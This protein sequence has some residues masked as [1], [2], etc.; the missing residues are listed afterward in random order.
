[1]ELKIWNSLNRDYSFVKS[2][3][4]RQ[5]TIYNCGPTVYSSPH[6]GNIRRFLVADLL[7]RT[8]KYLKCDVKSI[9]NITDVGHLLDTNHEAA[10]T[11]RM[12]LAAEREKISPEE[13]AAKYTAEFFEALEKLNAEPAQYYPRATMHIPFMIEVITK[14][15]KRGYAYETASG[16]YYDVEKFKQ[17][18]KLSGNT[19]AEVEAGAR[20]AVREEKKHPQDFALWIKAPEEHVMQWDSPW[21]R[22]YPG[23]HIE[24]SAM[25]MH[26][27][28]ETIDIHTGGEDNKFPHHEN[29]IAQSEGATGKEFS[30]IWLHNAHL[31]VDN[32]KMSKSEGTFIKLEELE[33]R[34]FDPLAFR[35]LCLQT[36]YRSK[37]NFTWK[38]LEAASE[39]LSNLRQF[40]RNL[41]EIKTEA[42]KP[43][44]IDFQNSENKFS[45]A[46]ADDLGSP[47]AIAVVYDMMRA[48]NSYISKG[49]IGKTEAKKIIQVLNRFNEVL[50][51]IDIKKIDASAIVPHEVSELLEKRETAR[52][53]K[54]FKMADELRKLIADRGFQVEDTPNG[55]RLTLIP[56]S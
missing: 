22:G 49:M 38:S 13:I 15:I 16:V 35:L 4:G 47:Q 24:C 6:I 8:L 14:L 45:E 27:L 12:M 32:K 31:L 55:P 43:V 29:E 2:P 28:G 53:E 7:V 50:A 11:D 3:K 39:A 46:L 23:W 52:K 9:M 48:V 34:G 21:G 30:R 37:L 25:A 5:V 41:M 17:Y 51:L 56:K 18:G 40:I 36:H 33:K 42:E 20:I 54:D 10:G 26:S 1:M 19:V 44:E